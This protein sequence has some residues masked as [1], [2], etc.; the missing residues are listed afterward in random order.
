MDQHPMVTSFRD[1]PPW[2]MQY[3]SV[4]VGTSHTIGI[5]VL[6]RLHNKELGAQVD[7]TLVFGFGQWYDA[8]EIDVGS[9]L[10]S[11]SS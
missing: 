1:F 6:D 9:A 4:Y 3:A 7:Q 8:P 11:A 10:A 2:I 5:T